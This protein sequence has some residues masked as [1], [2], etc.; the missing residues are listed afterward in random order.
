M[1]DKVA[2]SFFKGMNYDKFSCRKKSDEVSYAGRDYYS[3][4]Y[5]HEVQS[6]VR[7]SGITEGVHRQDD[8]G[9]AYVQ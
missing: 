4:K 7:K 5:Y 3:Q 6:D 1:A 2:F 8:E 9:Q